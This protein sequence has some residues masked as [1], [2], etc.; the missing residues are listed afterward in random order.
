M[1]PSTMLAVLV[2]ALCIIGGMLTSCKCRSNYHPKLSYETAREQ[3]AAAWKAYMQIARPFTEQD[4]I[5]RLAQLDTA[6]WN[7]FLECSKD[8]GDMGCDSCFQKI[9]GFSLEFK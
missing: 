9:Y 6:K 7:A 2:L 5:S 3:Q 1:K 8:E 4:S